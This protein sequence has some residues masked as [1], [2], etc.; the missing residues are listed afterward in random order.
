MPSYS[1]E[2]VTTEV[3]HQ[4]ERVAETVREHIAEGQH[5]QAQH[6]AASLWGALRLWECI[7][8]SDQQDGDA[9]GL[10]NAIEKLEEAAHKTP[11][12]HPSGK[13]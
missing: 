8:G 2:K 10:D 6:L 7:V 4:I 12:T 11:L 1:Y 5:E 13:I 9:W 3:R